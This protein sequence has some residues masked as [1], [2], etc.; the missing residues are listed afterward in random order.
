MFGMVLDVNPS[1]KTKIM[2][3]Y[4]YSQIPIAVQKYF[5]TQ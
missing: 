2:P 5:A 1:H 3:L 4:K